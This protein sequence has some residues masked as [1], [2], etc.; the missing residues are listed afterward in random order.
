MICWKH[1]Q[2]LKSRLHTKIKI[3]SVAPI[4]A[5]DLVELC[6][7]NNNYQ[8]AVRYNTDSSKYEQVQ[9][10]QSYSGTANV[11][12]KYIIIYK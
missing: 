11:G 1:Y 8:T 10:S 7:A 5:Y 2:H 3:Y 6:G 4:V 9:V 12:D